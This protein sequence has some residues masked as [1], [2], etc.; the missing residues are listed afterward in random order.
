MRIQA[1][2]TDVV[3][4]D[5]DATN[6]FLGGLEPA[7]QREDYTEAVS[8]AAQLVA[9]AAQ[10]QPADGAALGALN[11]SLLDYTSQV[12]QARA[13]NRQALPVG[14]QYLK[15]PAPTCVRTPCRC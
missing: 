3:Q 6:A 14:A 10:H 11:R 15:V 5:A 8:S 7:A 9:E 1:I 12:E 4:A 13:N 2:Q